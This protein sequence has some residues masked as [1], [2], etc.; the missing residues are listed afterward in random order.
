[1]V[2]YAQ[3]MRTHGVPGFPDPPSSAGNTKEAVI[4]VFRE[5][6]RSQVV[7]AQTACQR[8]QPNG[9]QPDQAQI[10]QHIG[11]LLAFARCMR[12]H[13][14]QNF[15]DPTSSG[16]VTHEMLAKAAV[17]VHQPAVLQAAD[18]CVG[19]THGLLTKAVVARFVAER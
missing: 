11:D 1:M 19:V 5:V 3:C 2:A 15:P 13:G 4:R 18:T 8:L 9:G 14:I 10:A 12:T 16:Q 7:A 6:G 17:D